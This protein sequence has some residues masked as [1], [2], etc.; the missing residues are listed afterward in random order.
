M[1]VVTQQQTK[2]NSKGDTEMTDIKKYVSWGTNSKLSESC[3]IS[4][5]GESLDCP[6]FNLGLCQAGEA[7][8]MRKI[9][10]LRPNNRIKHARQSETYKVFTP[11][12]FV[13]SIMAMV[14][15]SRVKTFNEFRYG[16]SGDFYNQAQVDWY[17]TV[18]AILRDSG[19]VVYGYTARTDLNLTQLV[20]NSQVNLSND[21]YGASLY[22]ELGANRFKAVLKYS[23]NADA[24][25]PCPALKKQG[26][27]RQCAHCNL[28]KTQSGL[29]E[30][31]LRK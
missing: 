17:A 12:A 23:G 3:I 29:I 16:E 21:R 25:C 10:K 4:N 1:I 8:Y 27:K 24:I 13:D 20:L 11:N 7:C 18:S 31:K 22:R 15:R 5:A 28:C 19:I 30:E 26:I 9:E 6:S 2:S 14:E